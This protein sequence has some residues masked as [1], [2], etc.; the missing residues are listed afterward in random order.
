MGVALGVVLAVASSALAFETAIPLQTTNARASPAIGRV[1]SGRLIGGRSGIPILPSG[2]GSQSAIAA[3]D[4][5]AAIAG[6]S[7]GLDQELGLRGQAAW[8]EE[9]D[10]ALE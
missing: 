8:I 10:A 4:E 6:G 7:V 2:S 9:E 1:K 5:D 3:P